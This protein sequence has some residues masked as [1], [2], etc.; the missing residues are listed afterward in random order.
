MIFIPLIVVTVWVTVVL[1]EPFLGWRS[2][3]QGNAT[4]P[5][6]A[7]VA[8]D[9]L[10][11]IGGTPSEHP[12][13][14]PDLAP[15]DFW[16]FRTM[17]RELR[18]KKP[19][20]PLSSWSLWQTVCSTFSR[21]GWSVVRNASLA[22]GGTSKKRPLSHLH[23]VPTRSNKVSRWTFQTTLVCRDSTLKQSTATA[24]VIF[25]NSSLGISYHSTLFNHCNWKN[26]VE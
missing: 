2:N 16:A 1:K 18:G 3:L 5:H 10:T 15:Y 13:Y 22:K 4:R 25:P 14:S 9:A 24:F 8:M 6:T 17:K 23:K 19:S 21:S 26:V 12:P 11:K 20:V 7:K